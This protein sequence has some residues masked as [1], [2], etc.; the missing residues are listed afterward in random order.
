MNSL[1]VS[2]HVHHIYGSVSVCLK[3]LAGVILTVYCHTDAQFTVS[4][5]ARVYTVC[6]LMQ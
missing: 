1:G 5:N 4:V 6:V 2:P 3:W